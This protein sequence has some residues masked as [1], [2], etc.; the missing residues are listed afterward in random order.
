MAVT[1][2][3]R[4]ALVALA[5]RSVLSFAGWTPAPQNAALRGRVARGASA[6]SDSEATRL[7]AKL[8]LAVLP[9][10][11]S[12]PLEASGAF[13]AEAL[14]SLADPANAP[15]LGAATLLEFE[16]NGHVATRG[17]FSAAEIN[18]LDGPVR[19]P[20]DK[21]LISRDQSPLHTPNDRTHHP[22]RSRFSNRLRRPRKM[23]ALSQ[24]RA[25]FATRELDAWV[26]SCR[27]ML[28]D[29]NCVDDFG[30]SMFETV[31]CAAQRD[32][33]TRGYSGF[34]RHTRLQLALSAAV[35]ARKCTVTHRAEIR[36]Q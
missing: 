2:C 11:P 29:E 3:T 12:R 32:A 9:P 25:A 24:V 30:L 17:L 18:A 36:P 16:R 31:A 14:A 19:L 33:V 23:P 13:V 28:G 1:G 7:V 10:P 4:F 8:G 6:S 35:V 21:H 22:A 27:V 34:H 26:H 20:Q 15:A 5:L